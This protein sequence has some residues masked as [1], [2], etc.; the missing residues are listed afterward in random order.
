MAVHY[1]SAFVWKEIREGGHGAWR[2]LVS[3]AIQNMLN[4]YN[5]TFSILYDF[6]GLKLAWYISCISVV[7]LV[8]HIIN[9]ST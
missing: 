2:Y 9:I 3:C 6:A 5:W 1:F 8:S 4:I 7:S